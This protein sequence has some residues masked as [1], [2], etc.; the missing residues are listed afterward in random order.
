MTKKGEKAVGDFLQS[1]S[2]PPFE[3]GWLRLALFGKDLNEPFESNEETAMLLTYLAS[4]HTRIDAIDFAWGIGADA[5]ESMFQTTLATTDSML[6]LFSIRTSTLSNRLPSPAA[7]VRAPVSLHSTLK[8]PSSSQP[9]RIPVDEDVLISNSVHEDV[10]DLSFSK[11]LSSSQSN[12]VLLEC[13]TA[14]EDV[15]NLSA[16]ETD[17]GRAM[18]ENDNQAF[19]TVSQ[20]RVYMAQVEAEKAKDIQESEKL[21]HLVMQG[22]ANKSNISRMQHIPNTKDVDY[23]RLTNQTKKMVPAAANGKRFVRRRSAELSE[24]LTTS[25]KKE[26][27]A[28]IVKSLAKRHGLVAL[29]KE[30]NYFSTAKLLAMKCKLGLKGNQLS[31]LISILSRSCGISLVPPGW[32]RRVRDFEKV[33]MLDHNAY[34]HELII[35]K[36][37]DDV[38]T[39]LCLMFC[40]DSPRRVVEMLVASCDIMANIEPSEMFSNLVGK[41]VVVFGGDKGGKHYTLL[42]RVANRPDGNQARH[43]QPLFQFEGGAENHENLA[44]T[45]FDPTK[46]ELPTFLEDL[47]H[48]R[49]HAIIISVKDSKGTVVNSRC[50]MVKFEG[51]RGVDVTLRRTASIS[52]GSIAVLPES[53][54]GPPV[55]KLREGSPDEDS[56]DESI[57]TLN[58]GTVASPPAANIL[59]ARLIVEQSSTEPDSLSAVVSESETEV[60]LQIEDG[61]ESSVDESSVDESSVDESSV[62]ESSIDESSIDGS[63]ETEYVGL[64]LRE[65]HPSE[66]VFRCKF[67]ESLTVRKDYSI[68]FQCLQTVGFP[69]QDE[70]QASMLYGQGGNSSLCSCLI[71]IRKTKEFKIFPLWIAEL[72]EQGHL[73]HNKS[74]FDDSFFV[75]EDAPFREGEHAN[76]AMFTNW[77]KS[78]APAEGH[79]T[80]KPKEMEGKDIC[81]S[82]VHATLVRVPVEKES[83]GPMH[84]PQGV[85][86]HFFDK[87]RNSITAVDKTCTGDNFLDTIAK[88]EESVDSI[89]NG[90]L[91]YAK[92]LKAYRALSRKQDAYPAKILALKAELAQAANEVERTSL[93]RKI[94]TME[95]NKK[96]AN[97]AFENFP[98]THEA[99]AQINQLLPAA[100]SLKAAINSWRNSNNKPKGPLLHVFNRSVVLL[101]SAEY[102]AEHGG[103]ELSHTHNIMVLEKWSEICEKVQKAADALGDGSQDAIKD[104]IENSNK[105][106]Y[107]LYRLCLLLK[108]QQKLG[109]PEIDEIRECIFLISVY[110]RKLYPGNDNFLVFLKLHHLEAHVLAFIIRYGFYGRPSEEGFENKHPEINNI[111]TNLR[112]VSNDKVKMGCMI[113]AYLIHLHPEFAR[114]LAEIEKAMSGKKRGPYNVANRPKNTL[115]IT[116]ADPIPFG[117]GC[118]KLYEDKIIKCEWLEVY[119]HLL[120]HI[121]PSSWC[122]AFEDDDSIEPKTRE[123]VRYE[124]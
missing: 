26:M 55:S 84:V 111:V 9:N 19:F 10:L 65:S 24:V 35:S 34:N 67:S 18:K 114:E 91:L 122:V 93:Q 118:L 33:V 40:Y 72:L 69:S 112:S 11:G 25:F 109:E 97:A 30:K 124:K 48:D 105:I 62:D 103:T 54:L 90:G 108:S 16:T 13:D 7:L 106:A 104:I 57:T 44:T 42:I 116:T 107:P 82:A 21:A 23:Y 120:Y 117:D 113:R 6:E 96:E 98:K 39:Q 92:D 76:T 29:Q 47:A 123:Q 86:K 22:L 56:D 5:R 63:G 53:P 43:S 75:N 20:V 3:E 15:L 28:P 58:G 119:L 31:G 81:A 37:G 94:D 38:K 49:L 8:D 50:E 52:E 46:S 89:L 80:T 102:R 66:P 59:L 61:D 74:D 110:W 88:T 77:G 1:K 95:T 71:C 115:K 45:A 4:K 101:T 78:Y 12:P 51:L 73:G 32:Q 99:F 87:V 17:I 83:M 14:D 36:S 27:V 64:E 2:V 41:L 68:E 100:K 60:E 121:V 85:C 79:R 70:K